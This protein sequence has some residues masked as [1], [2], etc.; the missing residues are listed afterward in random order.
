MNHCKY[1]GVFMWFKFMRYGYTE[2][3]V[4]M[5]QIS[6]CAIFHCIKMTGLSNVANKL[7]KFGL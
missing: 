4:K 7:N 1:I 2:K 6:I 3:L 5:F